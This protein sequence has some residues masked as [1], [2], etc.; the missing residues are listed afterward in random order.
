MIYLLTEPFCRALIS[1]KHKYTQHHTG[2]EE[3]VQPPSK[4]FCINIWRSTGLVALTA[5]E[6]VYM[7]MLAL[8][9]SGTV[10]KDQ[11]M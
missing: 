1:H 2:K 9:T 6:Q 8:V 5:S 3:T 10:E 4:Y 7:A 11:L